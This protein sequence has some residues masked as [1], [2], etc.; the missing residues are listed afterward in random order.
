MRGFGRA[1]FLQR[2][3]YMN[4]NLVKSH[5]EDLIKIIES[6]QHQA[7]HQA[8]TE[9]EFSQFLEKVKEKNS[10]IIEELD[11]STKSYL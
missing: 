2:S 7:E 1:F 11:I 5:I 8:L 9:Q 4:I 10:F 3:I 6:T